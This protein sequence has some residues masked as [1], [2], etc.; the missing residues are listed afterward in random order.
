MRLLPMVPLG[1]SCPKE[2]SSDRRD[3]LREDGMALLGQ[4]VRD[5]TN[6]SLGILIQ[7]APLGRA[8]RL[9]WAPK[10][11][12]AHV[13]DAHPEVSR[14]RPRRSACPDLASRTIT[15]AP[16]WCS[17]DLRDDNEA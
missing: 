3:M 5:M 13:Q 4:E 1:S 14:V 17:V 8:P 16:L 12:R 15:R 6:E 10:A 11:A 9:V 7:A 2:G